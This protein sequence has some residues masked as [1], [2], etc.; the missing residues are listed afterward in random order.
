MLSLGA[1]V[2]VLLYAVFALFPLFLGPYLELEVPYDTP[3]GTTV[4]AGVAQRVSSLSING[5]PIPV[6]EAG[7][8]SIE[9]AYPVGYT[10]VVIEATDRF[11]RVRRETLT[12]T[13]NDTTHARKEEARET[14]DDEGGANRLE[15]RLN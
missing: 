2:L 14:I 15:D 9:R 4:I 10:V 8:F 5:L 13:T 1:G 6:T 3:E 11:G 12:L 7:A